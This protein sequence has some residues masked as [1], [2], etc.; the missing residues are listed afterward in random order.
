MN[1]E[2]LDK[3]GNRVKSLEEKIPPIEKKL[4]EQEKAEK[5]SQEALEIAS[6]AVQW[7]HPPLTAVLAIIALGI[8]TIANIFFAILTI[9]A[10]IIVIIGGLVS[11]YFFYIKPNR[12]LQSKKGQ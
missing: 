3:L 11:I 10:V 2:E 8:F 5:N 7:W 12:Q 1:K 4:K 6:K 9:T